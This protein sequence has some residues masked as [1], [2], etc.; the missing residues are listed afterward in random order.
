M[1]LSILESLMSIESPVTTPNGGLM[2]DDGGTSA[3]AL[4]AVAS[5]DAVG[6]EG[7]SVQGVTTTADVAMYPQYLGFSYRG[8]TVKMHNKPRKTKSLF[9]EALSKEVG[10]MFEEYSAKLAKIPQLETISEEV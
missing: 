1:R 6:P 2:E 3:G 5:A 9:E 7:A 8:G 4:G 10:A